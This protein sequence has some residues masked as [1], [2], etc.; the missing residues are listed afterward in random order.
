MS[1]QDM[2][3]RFQAFQMNRPQPFAVDR[4]PQPKF[5]DYAPTPRSS[6]QFPMDPQAA[7][8]PAVQQPAPQQVGFNPNSGLS[9]PT[10]YTAQDQRAQIAGPREGF[11]APTGQRLPEQAG[12][13]MPAAGM[14][15][16]VGFNPN[17]G[18]ANPYQA[19]TMAMPSGGGVM[20]SG[21]LSPEEM[22]KQ[23]MQKQMA[24]QPQT[25]MSGF[26][27]M[28]GGAPGGLLTY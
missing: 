7:Q 25:T 11:A 1:F 9:A 2:R 19:P 20:N 22:Q 14:P 8:P 6:L 12:G 3:S 5:P 27:G 23:A 16:Q 15:Q 10:T 13:G 4:Q 24:M 18:L 17:G 21:Q 28:R 26:S